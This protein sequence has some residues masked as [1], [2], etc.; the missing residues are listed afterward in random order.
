MPR[1]EHYLGVAEARVRS[2]QTGS[3][4]QLQRLAQVGGDVH[5]MMDDYLDHQRSGAPVHEWSL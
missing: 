4:W 2:A 1:S 3:T 5:R